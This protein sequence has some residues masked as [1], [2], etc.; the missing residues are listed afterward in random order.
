MHDI[1]DDIEEQKEVG[2]EIAEAISRPNG[3]QDYDEVFVFISKFLLQ[4]HRV[5][6]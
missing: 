6:C 3:S 4:K 1:M 2:D 5:M